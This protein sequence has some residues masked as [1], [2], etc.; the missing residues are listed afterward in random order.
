L[1][2]NEDIQA[3][4]AELVGAAAGKAGVTI[5]R[6]AAELAKIGFSDVRMA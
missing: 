2:T 3:R 4:I 6:I 1:S 5:E